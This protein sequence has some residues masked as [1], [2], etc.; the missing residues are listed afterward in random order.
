MRSNNSSE[1]WKKWYVHS[2]SRRVP[3]H[4]PQL[5]A[6][7]GRRKS[8]HGHDL[9]ISHAFEGTTIRSHAREGRTHTKRGNG[10]GTARARGEGVLR[11]SAPRTCPIAYVSRRRKP[12]LGVLLSPSS[13][14]RH[15]RLSST[16]R[17]PRNVHE[18][19]K[20]S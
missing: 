5:L 20:K 7:L 10:E 3:L 8:G 1:N 14:S 13:P 4:P 2:V 19:R 15:G 9:H 6:K 12:R 16:R 17:W 18:K 11:H